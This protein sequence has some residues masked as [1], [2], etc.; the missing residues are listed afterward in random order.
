MTRPQK[1]QR[2]RRL[3]A[4]AVLAAVAALLLAFLWPD[5]GPRLVPSDPQG[6]SATS[7]TNAA[8]PAT[9]QPFP[10]PPIREPGSRLPQDLAA[11]RGRVEDVAGLPIAG[12]V[13][14]LGGFPPREVA[15]T[16]PAA[17]TDQLGAFE[18]TVPRHQPVDLLFL[19]A[20]HRPH[21]VAASAPL[22]DLL[23]VLERTPVLHGRVIHA[24]RRSAHGALVR[25]S[26]PHLPHHPGATT[27]T[28]HSGR[29]SFTNLP[30]GIEL[31]VLADGALPVHRF[32]M[33]DWQLPELLI[34]LEHG[35]EAGGRV[36]AAEDGAALVG[37]TVSLWYYAGSFTIEG[38]RGGP[39]QHAQTAT[40]GDD[41][42]F[43]LHLLPS[44]AERR[45][46]QAWLWVQAPGRAAHA[47]LLHDPEKIED[48][49]IELHQT[50]AVRGRV[51]DGSGAPLARHRVFAE[52]AIQP[53]CYDGK[54]P[55][56]RRQDSGWSPG[57][58]ERSP[59]FAAPFHGVREAFTDADGNY[60]IDEI[61]APPGGCEV[62]LNLADVSSVVRTFLAPGTT[63]VATDLVLADRQFCRR[64]GT[65]VD[66]LGRPI[67]GANVTIG[68]QNTSTDAN[69]GFDLRAM[70]YDD[71]LFVTAHGYAPYRQS[72]PA[73]PELLPPIV[74]ESG[75]TV[76]VR[77][78]DRRGASLPAAVVQVFA[79]EDL[80]PFLAGGPKP[81]ALHRT[82][83]D[84]RGCARLVAVP[85]RFDMLVEFTDATRTVHRRAL[86]RNHAEAG[87][88]AVSLE[89]FEL[90]LPRANLTV[91]LTE[92]G[93]QQPSARSAR[94]IAYSSTQTLQREMAG[95][96]LTLSDLP[97][98]DWRIVVAVDGM[99]GVEAKLT[100]EHD[101]EFRI[102]VGGASTLTGQLSSLAGGDLGNLQVVV[103]HLATGKSAAARAAP[104]G[105]F[106]VGGLAEGEYSVEV[107]PKP[108]A[109]ELPG[110]LR[111]AQTHASPQP[112]R[113]VAPAT[114][115][116]LALVLPV[117][118]IATVEIVVA[119][120]AAIRLPQEVWAWAQELNFEVVDD[121]G[122]RVGSDRATG[123]LANAA[124]WFLPM[125]AGEYSA[126]VR[127][128]GTILGTQTLRPGEVWR[129]PNR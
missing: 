117:I 54:N 75:H 33:V 72:L 10:A 53:L 109:E 1:R 32:V 49:V 47:R 84:D 97:L 63:A 20:Q 123:I 51:V 96:V 112:A 100:L 34:E 127:W 129:L 128:R 106:V 22:D 66:R 69:G 17:Q 111:V 59:D 73:Q 98:G 48:V 113:V 68:T 83:T 15:S 50:G 46:P 28:D 45:R 95:P 103:R 77:V 30:W 41:G 37:A 70:H 89:Q 120:P 79:A 7:A 85:A 44:S 82:R 101:Q 90:K 107:P 121:R 60:Q 104:D 40:T 78:T 55:A 36:V 124:E 114:P 4:A 13:I 42:R 6:Q 2:K 27:T 94:L 99:L 67:Q 18:L 52:S 16:G 92:G 58:L 81:T 71:R 87:S 93:S 39:T 118:P 86:T 29:F 11:I 125:A 105:T 74:L 43:Q 19:G 80:D 57:W 25:W 61:P 88:F 24:D 8:L 122:G 23:V 126:T 110:R 115:T 14:H 91:V 64:I 119:P 3:T 9:K 12:T 38:R 35:R 102:E 116:Q 76:T 31:E 26:T 5:D 56:F 65:V 21:R 62:T 108:L